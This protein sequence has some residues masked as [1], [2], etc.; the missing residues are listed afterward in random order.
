MSRTQIEIT[1]GILL[2]LVT[3]TFLIIYGL[4]EPVRMQ[5]L[6]LEQ[7]GR[8]V[9]VG[10]ELFDNNCKG[11]HG[12]QGEGTVG[13]CPPLNDKNFFNNRLKEVG[14][15]GSLEDYIVA[16][17]SSGRLASTRPELYPGNGKPAMPAWSDHYGGPLRDDQIRSIATFIM[18]WQS[19]APDRQA[20]VPTLSGPPVG[21]D[22]SKQLPAGDATKGQALAATQGCLG[23]H[24]ATT[25]GP[26]WMASG[27]TP[28]IGTRAAERFTQPDYTGNATSP[29]QYLFESIVTPDAFIVEGYQPIMPKTFGA[30]MTDQDVADLIAYLLTL[31]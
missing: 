22:T 5:Q 11:C 28:G 19:T 10:A 31:K 25:T 30:S 24:V 13:L 9:E 3:G 16:T 14:W 20:A 17:V 6:A 29:E 7:H 12:P 2:V 18:N 8:T 1:L 4:N 21:T 23:C 15:A 26:A 27:D